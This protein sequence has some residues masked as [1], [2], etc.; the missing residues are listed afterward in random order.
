MS[1]LHCKV[2]G[3]FGEEGAETPAPQ[4]ADTRCALTQ[5]VSFQGWKNPTATE[6]GLMTAETRLP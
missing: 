3:G 4:G 5:L 2:H 1:P 6:P